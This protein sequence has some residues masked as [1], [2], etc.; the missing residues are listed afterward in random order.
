LTLK[1]ELDLPTLSLIVMIAGSVGL[2]ILLEVT[3]KILNAKT[4]IQVKNLKGHT[5]ESSR[6]AD[7]RNF[8]ISLG[9]RSYVVTVEE[10][11]ER[12]LLK[13]ETIS[14]R[15][16]V[17]S[18]VAVSED[19]ERCVVKA[20]LPGQVLSIKCQVGESVTVDSVLLTLE[21]MKMENEIMAPFSGVVKNI[22]VKEGQTVEL[23]EVLVELSD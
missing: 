3:K 5:A 18:T 21:A 14:P 22:M 7:S 4:L 13:P 15:Q 6:S 11:Q 23:G 19:R 9:D 17:E 10:L 8:K 12:A 16:E 1:V 20:P 2:F